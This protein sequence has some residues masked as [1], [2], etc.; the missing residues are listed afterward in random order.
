VPD[1]R[2]RV[3]FCLSDASQD[4]RARCVRGC[5]PFV[6]ADVESGLVTSSD[7]RS[8]AKLRP[9][10]L[11]RL[12]GLRYFLR[13]PNIYNNLGN[14][15]FAQRTKVVPTDGVRTHSFDT[16]RIPRSRSPWRQLW[17]ANM[18]AYKCFS[19]WV[20]TPKFPFKGR[21]HVEPRLPAGFDAVSCYLTQW[22]AI[23]PEAC[24]C[25]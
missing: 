20:K 10:E 19:H 16:E 12:Q 22:P 14:L 23:R 18:L 3:L 25:I 2:P 9:R 6:T 21:L 24:R 15:L 17:S 13:S 8:G 1:C 11:R 5:K 7:I 4:L